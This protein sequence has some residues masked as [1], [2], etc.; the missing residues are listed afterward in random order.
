MPRTLFDHVEAPGFVAKL[1]A[2]GLAKTQSA[3]SAF[4]AFEDIKR[5]KA[6]AHREAVLAE[7][8]FVAASPR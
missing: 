4:F 1:L 6:R 5:R 7:R 2:K 8:G 3:R